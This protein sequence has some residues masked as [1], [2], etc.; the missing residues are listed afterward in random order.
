MSEQAALIHSDGCTGVT[1]LYGDCCRQHDVEGF[2]G[3]SATDAYRLYLTGASDYWHRA[4][5]ITFEEW[6]KHFRSCHFRSSRLGHWSP[7]AW[8]RYGA[9][10]MRKGRAAWDAHR[11]RERE[12]R[13]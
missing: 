10:R 9:V 1:N 13:T 3:R 4:Q 7:L 12:A 5:P 6:N 8:A 2:H 11:Q